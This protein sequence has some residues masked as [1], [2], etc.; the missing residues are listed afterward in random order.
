MTIA[1]WND[2]DWCSATYDSMRFTTRPM[3]HVQNTPR[4][5]VYISYAAIIY[6]AGRHSVLPSHTV[7]V[8]VYLLSM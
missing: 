8:P 5:M 7:W 4:L 3:R 2:S 1:S 6:W